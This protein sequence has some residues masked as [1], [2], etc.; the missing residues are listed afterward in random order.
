M[1]RVR[2]NDTTLLIDGTNVIV[3]DAFGDITQEEIN[4]MVRYLMAEDFLPLDGEINVIVRRKKSNPENPP[5][6]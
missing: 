5:Q 3:E 4:A 6:D 2:L 1:E